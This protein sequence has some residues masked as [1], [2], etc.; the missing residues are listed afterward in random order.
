MAVEQQ[1]LHSLISKG[2]SAAWDQKWADAAAF[3][4]QALEIEPENLRA[5]TSLGLAYYEMR[6]FDAA[7][8]AY[9]QAVSLNREDPA[10][11]EK[12]YLIYRQLGQGKHAV[13]SALHAADAHL[14][15]EDI[16]KSIENWKRVVELDVL[17]VKAHARLAMVYQRLGKQKLAV[18]EYLNAASILQQSGNLGK[19]REAIE[20]ALEFS[21]ENVIALRAM[22][23]IRQGRQL[24]LPEP[25][26]KDPEME[27]DPSAPQLETPAI[28]EEQKSATPIEEAV[29]KA[30][31]IMAEALF[32]EKTVARGRPAAGNDLREALSWNDPQDGQSSDE[33][34][35][36]LYISQAIEQVTA[37]N[38]QD[39]AESIKSAVD[40]GFATPAAF[41]MMGYLHHETGRLESAA[42]NLNKAVSH[43]DFAL[44]SRLLMAKYYRGKEMW[45]Q[46]STEY[47]EAL[48]IA[49][50]SLVQREEVDDLI[51]LYEAMIDDL[52]SQEGGEAL[53]RMCDHI[54]DLLI[55]QDWREVLS[56]MRR[57][58]ELDGA[59]LLPQVDG[60][61]EDRRGQVMTI[62]QTIQNL[63]D[64]GRYGA[65]MERA[66][67]A[68]Q[69]APTFL[70]LHVTIGDILLHQGKKSGAVDKYLAVAD[71]YRVQG[72]TERSLSVLKKV[73]EVEAM[74]IDV[75][76]RYVELLEEYGQ[77]EKAIVEYLGLADVYWTLA[78]LESAREA[79]QKA[80]QLADSLPRKSD[81]RIKILLRQAD[82]D[83]QQ[84]DWEGA[85]KT[86]Q[87]VINEYPH[88]QKASVAIV[89]L[90]ARLGNFDVAEQEIDR[91]IGQFQL[92]DDADQVR[93]YLEKL[94][95]E[96]PDDV[97]II[98]RL[99]R[100]YHQLG[101]TDAAIAELDNFGDTLLDEGRT[102]DV[103]RV[104]QDIISF[105]PPNADE[106]RKLLDQLRA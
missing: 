2:H 81:W 69:N 25:Q 59:I 34:Y 73:I 22:E 31:S 45:Q 90:N 18:S 37:E 3:Y 26:E 74:N 97:N 11:Y 105:N 80:L 49:D 72:K 15:N 58:G 43:A 102:E 57:D 5:L 32:Q 47:I 9:S 36:K 33:S 40:E 29:E 99:A 53:I 98:R 6:D 23:N 91:F 20:R 75:R 50:T 44:G 66:F 63:V 46:A 71:V 14:K 48:R 42:R 60:I 82:I 4:Q 39:A 62:H 24:P 83:I 35:L 19:A 21:P 95:N 38:Y 16:Q 55:R 61:N 100:F 1:E 87:T 7:L 17:N 68:L 70:P 96:K 104:I 88:N 28:V 93:S 41:F 54:D 85:L 10:P 30:M 13:S 106:Y 67:F 101:D 65:A 52:E 64:D 79:S 27:I 56:E 84:L 94:K 89:D 8:E 12:M 103:I 76:L 77:N 78:E 86:F 92:P 51:H